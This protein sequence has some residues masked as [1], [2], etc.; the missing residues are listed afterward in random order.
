M[1]YYVDVILP[2][3]VPKALT[4]RVSEDQFEKLT[5]GVRVAVPLRKSSVLTGIVEKLHSVDP[6]VYVPREIELILDNYPIVTK[7]QLGFWEW[8]SDYYMATKG[9]IISAA[10]PSTLLLK[11]ETVFEVN[12]DIQIEQLNLDQTM[13]LI[14]STLQGNSLKISEIENQTQLRRILPSMKKMLDKNWIVV[15]QKLEDKYR[16]LVSAHLRLHPDYWDKLNLRTAIQGLSRAKKQLELLLE[17]IKLNPTH[18]LWIKVSDVRQKLD[19]SSNTIN[20]LVAKGIIEKN[21]ISIERTLLEKIRKQKPKPLS[22]KQQQALDEIRERFKEKNTVLLHGVTSS[23][24]TEVYMELMDQY[25]NKGL[26]VLY[27]LPEISLTSQI[28]LRLKARFGEIVTVYHSKYNLNERTEVWY[29]VLSASKKARVIVGTRSALMLPFKNLGLIIVDEEHESS[30]KQMDPAPRYNAR[31]SAV[32]LGRIIGAKVLLGSASPSIETYRNTTN[33]KY[34]RVNL[35]ERYGGVAMPSIITIDMGEQ[36]RNKLVKGVFSQLMLDEIKKTLDRGKQVILFQNR[37]GYSP[38]LKCTGCG[39]VPECK[40][41][42]VTLIF[43]QFN[44]SLCCHLCNYSIQKTDSCPV[45]GTTS[46]ITKGFGTQQIQEQVEKFFPNNPVVRMDKDTTSKKRS[47]DL[48]LKDF[49]K[50]KY[51]ILVG[52][53]MIIKGLDFKNVLLVGVV[54]ADHSLNFPDFRSFERTFQ[55]LSQ[56]AGRAGRFDDQGKV[57]LQTYNP[58]NS[59]IQAVVDYDYHRLYQSELRDRYTFHYPPFSKLIYITFK[60]RQKYLVDEAANW[61]SRVLSKLDYGKI[62]GPGYPPIRRINN[63]YH[64]QIVIKLKNKDPLTGTK[65]YLRQCKDR[66]D[67]I[68]EFR[69]VRVNIDVDPY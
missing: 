58:R 17:L 30:Y 48:I 59:V 3:A 33:G 56:V 14:L 24:K 15:Q 2:L 4:Y 27:L 19:V 18:R 57:L 60:H 47:F 21:M 46:L 50:K 36:N 13:Y 41:C 67:A 52:T 61:F 10:L 11:S 63:K 8:I 69:G 31:D 37:R 45:C 68:S 64:K 39:Y 55:I 40:Q 26:Q 34:A 66:F 6:E 12:E 53:Q 23:G 16:P 54:D 29:K 22:K 44:S 42:D 1:P 51:D 7:Q 65:T 62:L 9:E 49:A 20:S 28:V 38:I 35:L 25:A 32:Y 5:I 43:H